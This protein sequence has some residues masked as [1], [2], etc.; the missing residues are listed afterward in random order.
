MKLLL[1]L[2]VVV[3]GIVTAVRAR[4]MRRVLEEPAAGAER[5]I[6]C[7][8]S[9]VVT[10]GP[11]HF[12]CEAC[13]YEGGPGLAK[14]QAQARREALRRLPPDERRRRGLEGLKE[15]H[16][17]LIAARGTLAGVAVQPIDESTTEMARDLNTDSIATSLVRV[18]GEL[19]RARACLEDAA[20]C[21]DAAVELPPSAEPEDYG[22]GLPYDP[23]ALGEELDGLLMV[24]EEALAGEGV[25]FEPA[26][27]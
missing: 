11:G 7:G 18:A 5:C 2:F 16:R 26:R 1:L 25:P 24:T 12:R 10:V 14:K 15:A 8:A 23:A 3:G 27:R 19:G 21:L 4:R 20:V 13:G 22:D 17:T 6:A 9:S